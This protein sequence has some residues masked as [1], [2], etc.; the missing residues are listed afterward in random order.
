MMPVASS[1]SKYGSQCSEVCSVMTPN[2]EMSGL[3]G[4]SRRSAQLQG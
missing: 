1:S 3:R 2:V 4:F